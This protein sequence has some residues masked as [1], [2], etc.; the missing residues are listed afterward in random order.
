MSD[1][2]ISLQNAKFIDVSTA[3]H[4]AYNWSPK[5]PP[6]T[7]P[8]TQIRRITIN[9]ELIEIIQFCLKICDP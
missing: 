6:P 1:F 2:I 3:C 9:L 4:I 5:T 8:I 7:C